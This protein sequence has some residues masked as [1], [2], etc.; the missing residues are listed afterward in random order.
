MINKLSRYVKKKLRYLSLILEYSFSRG[1]KKA[2]RASIK[3]IADIKG[4]AEFSGT[5][6]TNFPPDGTELVIRKFRQEQMIFAT[7]MALYPLREIRGFFFLLMRPILGIRCCRFVARTDAPWADLPSSIYSIAIRN[8]EA[9]AQIVFPQSKHELIIS[10][11]D[12]YSL[13]IFNDD[14][15]QAAR[16]ELFK[17]G[18]AGIEDLQQYARQQRVKEITCVVSEYT[19]SARDNGLALFRHLRTEASRIDAYYVIERKNLDGFSVDQ[20]GVLEFGS[21]EHLKRCIDAQVAAFSHH[22]AYAYPRLIYKIDPERY[23]SARTLFLQHGVTALK[24]SV[25]RHYRKGRAQYSAVAVCSSMERR[26]FLDE[27]DYRHNEVFVTGFARHDALFVSSTSRRAE[28]RILVFPTW[29]AG[30]EKMTSAEAESTEFVSEWRALLR[31]LKDESGMKIIFM[32]HPII[33]RHV[34]LFEGYAHDKIQPNKFQRE[35]LK[36]RC[37]ITDYS[38][39]CFDALYADVPVVMFQFDRESYGLE[40]DAFIDIHTQLPGKAALTAEAAMAAVNN[41]KATGWMVGADQHRELYFDR[42]DGNNCSRTAD[43]I[44]T[45]ALTT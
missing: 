23:R 30:L 27:F 42:R 45:L 33:H 22:R 3:S 44:R 5:I 38:S 37:L 2:I 39:V 10:P 31:R 11:D 20:P 13:Y 36:A 26:I 25:Q 7:T 4:Q 41:L 43:V 35:L 8:A 34:G 9:R 32:L 18:R 28:D 15:V 40:R 12:D 6:Y 24:R 19:N 14:V 17:F 1:K 29:R 16:L 21:I